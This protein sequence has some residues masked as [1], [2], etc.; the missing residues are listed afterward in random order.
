[1]RVAAARARRPTAHDEIAIVYGPAG[2]KVDVPG[3]Y[4]WPEGE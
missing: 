1:L 3:S 4:D 2:Q